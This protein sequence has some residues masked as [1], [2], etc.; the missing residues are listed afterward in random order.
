MNDLLVCV[1]GPTATGKTAV[2]IEL[3]RLLDG[4]IISADSMAGYKGM[5]I[6]TA[7][8]TRSEQAAARF[9]LLDV[10]APDEEFSVAE[11]RRLAIGA[12]GD[13]RSRGRIPI[14]VG[15]TGLYVRSLT[16]SL[17]I[18]EVKADNEYREKLRAEAAESGGEALLERLRTV[19]PDSADRLHKNDI[20]RII[21]ALE[22]YEKTG[23]PITYFQSIKTETDCRVEMFGLTMSRE[24][25]YE[26]IEQRIDCMLEAGFA[27]E[28]SSLLKRGYSPELAS[29]KGL[30]YKHLSD[31]FYGKCDLESAVQL[32][33]RDTRRFAKRQFTWFRADSRIKWLDVEDST[34]L[35]TAMEIAEAVESD[36]TSNDSCK[37]RVC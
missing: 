22:V 23:R 1:V 8:P 31:L 24:K 10:A 25:L 5:G 33:K 14:L 29:M 34:P 2:G 28:V 6:G 37:G 9:H 18:P 3:A 15:G 13:I 21:R 12:M 4:E 32:L 17:N 7:K 36:F 35:K 27:D 20:Y 19:D 26:R 30:G 16:G 11:F